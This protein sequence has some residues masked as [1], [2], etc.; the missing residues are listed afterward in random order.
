M[1]RTFMRVTFPR[2][3]DILFVL[4]LIGTVI[5]AFAFAGIASNFSF[6][7]AFLM[8]ITTIISGFVSVLLIFGGIYVLFDIRDT[9][10]EMQE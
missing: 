3:I 5:A 1:I 9:L 2:L 6:S 7:Y 10:F 8:F 4:S